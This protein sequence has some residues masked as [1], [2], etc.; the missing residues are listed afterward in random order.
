MNTEEHHDQRLADYM[1]RSKF[2]MEMCE[3]EGNVEDEHQAWLMAKAKAE[4]EVNGDF[5]E[6]APLCP[7]CN[8]DCLQGRDCPARKEKS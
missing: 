6:D 8:N 4:A 2:Y 1:R 7:P 5:G 3:R